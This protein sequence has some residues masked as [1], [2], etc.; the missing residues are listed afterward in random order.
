MKI[1][2]NIWKETLFIAL[3]TFFAGAIMVVVFLCLDKFDLKVLYGALYGC[4][5]AVLN[6]FFMAY[7]LQKAM[8]SVKDESE[9]EREKLVKMKIKAYYSFRSLVYL[10][11]LA[12]ALASKQFNIITLLTPMVFPQIT[13][14][15]RLLWLGKK[16]EDVPSSEDNVE[17]AETKNTEE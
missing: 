13:A 5:V 14:R 7:S 8:K 10:L 3:G 9:E 11:A 2:K 4:T 12:G 16:G 1:D 17:N 6:F 15:I